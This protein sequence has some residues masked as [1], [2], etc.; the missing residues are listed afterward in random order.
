M[1]ITRVTNM[2]YELYN[3]NKKWSN[4]FLPISGII[5]KI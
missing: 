2:S 3:I 5:K 1:E 4:T